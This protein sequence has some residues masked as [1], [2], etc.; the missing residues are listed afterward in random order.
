[1][2]KGD[3]LSVASILRCILHIPLR[4]AYSPVTRQNVHEGGLSSSRGAHDGH[5][6]S[7]CEVPRDAFQQRLVTWNPEQKDAGP[8]SLPPIKKRNKILTD[9]KPTCWEFHPPQTHTQHSQL[10]PKKQGS[11]YSFFLDSALDLLHPWQSQL[12]SSDPETHTPSSSR[13]LSP[14]NRDSRCPRCWEMRWSV[15]SP[16]EFFPPPSEW[17]ANYATPCEP[18]KL[19]FWKGFKTLTLNV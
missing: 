8:L 2:L 1:M 5:Q 12:G 9:T 15:R 11:F 7:A 6:T 14:G 16:A 17:R 10:H 18:V 19:S 13:I 4:W 3:G